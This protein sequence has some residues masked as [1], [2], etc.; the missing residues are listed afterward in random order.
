M[1]GRILGVLVVIILI[2]A[3][4]WYF[5]GSKNAQAP[6]P[7]AE[8]TATT[9][10]TGTVLA[11]T[12]SSTPVTVTY[13]DQGFSPKTVTVIEGTTVTFVNESSKRMWVGADEH[14]T[15]TEY[16]GTSKNDHCATGY[17]GAPA[18]D[19]C[20]A[21]MKGTNYSFTFTKAGTW[22]YHNHAAA[23]DEGSVV[24]TPLAAS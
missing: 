6:A 23:A 5:T 8:Q 3:G 21:T 7:T 18:F 20:T 4:V 17:T 22:D 12:A 14:P 16:D 13:T 1:N 10:V 2:G 9:T 19:Q 11:D 24:V 15:H